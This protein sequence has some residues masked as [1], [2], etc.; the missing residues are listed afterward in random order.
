MSSIGMTLWILDEYGLHARP[1]MQIVEKAQQFSC[2]IRLS[3]NGKDASAK[4]IMET[5]RL[6]AGRGTKLLME[7]EGEDSQD[8]INHLFL[9][10]KQIKIW[11]QEPIQNV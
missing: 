8:A 5:M 2:D 10:G 4:S 1:A 11:T 9:F 6:G 7:A 3:C